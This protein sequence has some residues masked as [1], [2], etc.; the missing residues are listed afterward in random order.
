MQTGESSNGRMASLE[1]AHE[2]PNPSSPLFFHG[3]KIPSRATL[4]RYGLPLDEWK[5]IA[6]C[7]QYVCFVCQNPPKNGRLCIDHFHVRLWKKMKPQDRKK[8][9]RGLLC[10]F[11]NS[12]YVSRSMT[13]PKAKRVVLYL[14]R[15]ANQLILELEAQRKDAV[16]LAVD[17]G[18]ASPEP[19]RP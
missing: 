16:V 17:P 13:L 2:G 5:T 12:R 7:Q 10:W 4:S 14:E 18:V 11:C 15:Y 8:F 6:I 19:C 3:L 9:V 1:V